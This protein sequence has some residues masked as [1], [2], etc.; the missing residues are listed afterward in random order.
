MLPQEQLLEKFNALPK[1][2]QETLISYESAD[3]IYE[4]AQKEGVLDGVSMIAEIT[5][6]VMMGL[7]PITKFRQK[8]QDGLGINEEKARRIAGVIRDK[9]FMQVKDELRVIHGLK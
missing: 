7:V 8:I 9:I 3:V 4:T 2:L 6:D 1:N 5:G